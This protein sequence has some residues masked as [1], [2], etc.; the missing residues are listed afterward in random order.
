MGSEPS[1]KRIIDTLEA[2]W[3]KNKT[4]VA[5]FADLKKV[6]HKILLHK[7]EHYGIQP[8]WFKSYLSN[9]TQYVD[10]N[11]TNSNRQEVTCGVPQGSILGPLLFLIFIND[12]H[13]STKMKTILFADDTTLI[14]SGAYEDKLIKDINKEL[15]NVHTWFT[16]NQLTV[17]PEKTYFMVTNSKNP[18][19]FNGSLMLHNVQL[20]RIG[21]EEETK[22]TKFVGLLLDENLTWKHH[23]DHV[24][25]KVTQQSFIIIK[26]RSS[27]PLNI[28]KLLYNSIIKP[29]L[30]YGAHIWGHSTGIGMKKLERAQKRVIRAVSNT[31]IW[32]GHTNSLFA[33]HQILKLGDLINMNTMKIGKQIIMKEVPVPLHKFVELVPANSRTRSGTKIIMKIPYSKSR[34]DEKT[35]KARLPRLWNELEEDTELHHCHPS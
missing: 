35:L 32:N 26:N 1:T 11:G 8:Q 4:N 29:H 9:R 21:E 20:N 6:N 15:A 18:K 12:L 27:L 25:K 34:A 22:T 28:R 13:R 7:L 17:H 14:A 33:K 5:I 10:I 23:I 31:K 24:A 16:Q 30:E 2:L 3:Q 19:K